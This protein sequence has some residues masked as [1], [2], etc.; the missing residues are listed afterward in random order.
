MGNQPTKFSIIY[1]KRT[2]KNKCLSQKSRQ[3]EREIKHLILVI[4]LAY[5]ERGRGEAEEGDL[6]YDVGFQGK[7]KEMK[8]KRKE[9]TLKSN[10]LV[11]D[12]NTGLQ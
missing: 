7:K 6:I 11:P 4:I 5:L 10:A 12:R 9:N 8:E 1:K 3:G 2:N